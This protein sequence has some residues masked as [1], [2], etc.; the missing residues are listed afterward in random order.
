VSSILRA[1][2]LCAALLPVGVHACTC[3]DRHLPDDEKIRLA[4]RDAKHVLLARVASYTLSEGQEGT[5][6][7]IDATFDPVET[8]KGGASGLLSGRH[9]YTA[10]A[11]SSSCSEGIP[12]LTPGQNVLLYLASPEITEWTFFYCSRSRVVHEPDTDRE[13]LLLRSGHHGAES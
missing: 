3:R 12:P 7:F 13:V 10:G 4:F 1:L 2:A 5:T 8:F 6:G 11:Y 9:E